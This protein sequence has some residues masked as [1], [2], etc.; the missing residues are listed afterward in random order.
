MELL[1][2][3]KNYKGKGLQIDGLYQSG[4]YKLNFFCAVINVRIF[5]ST[6]MM[7]NSQ[8]NAVYP[9]FCFLLC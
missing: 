3:K 1:P 8:H 9:W 6:R 4:S 5:S 7:R 2:W